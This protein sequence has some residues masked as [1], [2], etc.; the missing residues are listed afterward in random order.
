MGPILLVQSLRDQNSILNLIIIGSNIFSIDIT[1]IIFK[2]HI[3]RVIF[4][5]KTIVSGA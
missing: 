5:F 3:V 1:I 2:E 4:S